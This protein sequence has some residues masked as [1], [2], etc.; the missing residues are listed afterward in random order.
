MRPAEK[1]RPARAN[2]L[3][4]VAAQHQ[5]VAPHG[6]HPG[7]IGM[8]KSK[9]LTR[10]KSPKLSRSS[11]YPGV[12]PCPQP[13]GLTWGPAGME[14]PPPLGRSK[15]CSRTKGRLEFALPNPSEAP[16]VWGPQEVALSLTF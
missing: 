7:S 9:G 4:P 12:S 10:A 6:I 15:A 13:P 3:H 5:D 11:K 2:Q 8:A 1:G 16:E 14:A